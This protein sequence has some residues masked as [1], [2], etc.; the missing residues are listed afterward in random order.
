MKLLVPLLMCFAS[1]VGLTAEYK[2]TISR[3]DFGDDIDVGVKER[4]NKQLIGKFLLVDTRTGVMT[5]A[6]NNSLY[7][8]PLLLNGG[9]SE[10]SFVSATIVSPRFDADV[11]GV[12]T[13][14]ITIKTWQSGSKKPFSLFWDDMLMRGRCSLQ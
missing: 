8:P 12:D 9:D 2:C 7:K 11:V 4:W 5:G 14:I 3:I 6:L 10:N 1:A 13:R